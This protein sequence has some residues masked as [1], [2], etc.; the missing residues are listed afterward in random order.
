M[1][2]F[3]H[4]LVKSDGNIIHDVFASS[5]KDL[6]NKYLSYDEIQNKSYFKAMYSPKDGC[7]F[8]DINNY[9][10]IVSE[11]YVPDWFHGGL[12]EDVM[13][14]LKNIISSMIIRTR[15]PLLLHEGVILV[16]NAVI[17]EVKHSIVFGMYD[18]SKIKSLDCNSEIYVM[19]DESIID[20]TLDSTKIYEMYGYSKIKKMSDYSKVMK[21]YGQARI[22]VMHNHSRIAMLKGDANIVEMHDK[23]KADRLKHMSRVDEMHEHSVIEEMW[24]WTVVEKMFDN[25]RINSMNNESKVLE[26]YGNSIIEQMYGKSVVERLC[27]NSLVRKLHGAAQILMQDLK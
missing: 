20:E 22:G 18:N 23:T 16:G 21:M 1:K 15:K 17:D 25:A 19:A 26:M 2:E 27:E 4:I 10:F 12:A 24:D 13:I 3:Y 7:R 11:T 14:M 9:Q 6:I 5:H 8:D